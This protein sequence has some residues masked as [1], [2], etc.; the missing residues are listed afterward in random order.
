[1]KIDIKNLESLMGEINR[2]S[3]AQQDE[4]VVRGLRSVLRAGQGIAKELVTVDSGELR[5]SIRYKTEKDGNGVTGY[6]YTNSDHA[7]YKEFGTGPVGAASGGNGSDVPVSYAQGPWKHVSKKGTVFYTDYWIYRDEDGQF[8]A[9]KGQPAQPF[10][11]PAAQ[12]AKKITGQILAK[13][14]QRFV[15]KISGGD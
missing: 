4:A 11:Y 6:L 3:G 14:F 15:K 8:Y 9:T 5:N 12:A 1:M 13:S 10:M 2:L 7:A